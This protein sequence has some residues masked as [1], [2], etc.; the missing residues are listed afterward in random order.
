MV[1]TAIILVLVAAAALGILFY[2]GRGHDSLTVRGRMPL[3]IRP[4]DLE[5]FHN[6]MDPAEDDYLRRQLNSEDYRKVRRK[7][8]LAA[9]EYVR[10][11]SQNAAVLTAFG[12]VARQ[13][14][15]ARIAT[16]GRQMV[17]AAILLRLLSTAV[18]FRLWT[19]YAFPRAEVSLGSVEGRYQ[20][21]KDLAWQLGNLENP[22]T[23]S[24]L[25]GA[26]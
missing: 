14:A 1:I 2:A 11:V 22:L 4:V 18:I 19:G 17:E 9:L 15:D 5:A 12:Q 20:S 8:I 23:A 3:Q 16:A 10:A 6:L 7:R 21:L 24:R 26:L 13:S 25:A